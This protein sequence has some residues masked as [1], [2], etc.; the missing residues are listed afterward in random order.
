MI[1]STVHCSQKQLC[2][3]Y[4]TNLP[5]YLA[6]NSFCR[7]HAMHK[8]TVRSHTE[9]RAL[10]S[11]IWRYCKWKY[12][13]IQLRLV[14]SAWGQRF[15]ILLVVTSAFSSHVLKQDITRLKRISDRSVWITTSVKLGSSVDKEVFPISKTITNPPSSHTENAPPFPTGCSRPDSPLP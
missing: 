9:P 13:K 3:K 12:I 14:R 6:Q 4:E 1:I 2:R 10:M 8:H 11:A 15:S 5:V 7:L